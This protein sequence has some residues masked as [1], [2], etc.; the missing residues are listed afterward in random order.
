MIIECA[1]LT[2]MKYIVG[3]FAGFRCN[4]FTGYLQNESFEGKKKVG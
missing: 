1:V 2:P 4:F 3:W